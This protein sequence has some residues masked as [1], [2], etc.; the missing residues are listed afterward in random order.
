MA[1]K[2]ALHLAPRT[3]DKEYKGRKLFDIIEVTRVVDQS[4]AENHFAGLKVNDPRI[5]VSPDS[6]YNFQYTGGAGIQVL[7]SQHWVIVTAKTLIAF[8][9]E[10]YAMATTSSMF[11]Y[12]LT[13]QPPTSITQA[14]LGQFAGTKEQQIVTASGS[15]IT[16]HRPDATQGKI[17]TL[18]SQDVFGIIRTLAAFRLA[19]SNKGMFSFGS[20]GEYI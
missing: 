4:K 11:M 17:T 7:A 8:G 1:G 3:E 19:G 16:L 13:I 18:L 20:P 5:C 15:R 6:D 10:L 2:S 14:I 9:L 12:S